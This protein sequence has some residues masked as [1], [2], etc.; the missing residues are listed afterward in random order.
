MQLPS[1][2]Q[3]KLEIPLDEIGHHFIETSREKARAILNGSDSRLAIIV[4]PCSIHDIPSALEYATRLQKLSR[5][6]EESCLL[7][8]RVYPEKPRTKLGWKGLLYDPHL[9]GS[10]DILRGIYETRKLL[11]TLAQ[12]GVM[13]AAEFVEPLASSYFEDLIT[14][15]FIGARTSESQP[16]RQLASSLAMPIGFKNA[17]DGDIE[18]A[19]NGVISSQN[20]HAF[21]SI[22][23]NGYIS[24]C[25]SLGNPHS[26]I[27]LRGSL[28][29]SNYDEFSVK[30]IYAQLAKQGLPARVM[31]DCAHGNCERQYSR[32]KEVFNQIIERCDPSIFGLMLESHL[33]AG[34]L[35]SITDPCIDWNTTEELILN[36]HSR[37]V[38]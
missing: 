20:P 23:Q 1:P 7:I 11:V 30:S 24:T 38:Y 18:G 22:D 25:R 31:I 15:G 33:Q 37:L 14:W 35:S 6:V 26:H 4:G 17:T 19:V 36:A 12:M 8:M 3:L 10:H 29:Q 27:V 5:E 9:D 34:N 21:L 32:Q 28:N 16:H 2:K 13:A